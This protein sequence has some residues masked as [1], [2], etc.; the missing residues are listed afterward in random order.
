M[1]IDGE[2]RMKDELYDI[3]NLF[4]DAEKSVYA[5]GIVIAILQEHYN[6]DDE[7]EMHHTLLVLHKGIEKISQELRKPIG[8][9]DNF[10]IVNK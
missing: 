9:L 1:H 2:K 10:L 5:M 3:M 7:E 6:P 8:M 4:L